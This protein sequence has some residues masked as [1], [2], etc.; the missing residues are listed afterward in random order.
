MQSMY[1]VQCP[2]IL[3]NKSLYLFPLCCQG[4]RFLGSFSSWSCRSYWSY[5]SYQSLYILSEY[6]ALDL[7]C[8]CVYVHLRWIMGKLRTPNVYILTCIYS[9]RVLV[10]GMYR[11]ILGYT[12]RREGIG[13]LMRTKLLLRGD[14]WV[15]Y[16]STFSLG[17]GR[18]FVHAWGFSSAE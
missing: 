4:E 7:M 13:T 14:V 5:W 11:I 9:T 8:L 17:N 12:S 15:A 3:P 10:T 16:A 2:Y 1:F 6:Q 18:N